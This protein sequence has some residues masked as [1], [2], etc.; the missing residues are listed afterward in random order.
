MSLVEKQ[1]GSM[2]AELPPKA[3]KQTVKEEFKD[4][5]ERDQAW[6]SEASFMTGEA[7]S[8]EKEE[9]DSESENED[10]QS[11]KPKAASGLNR[12]CHRGKESRSK[13]QSWYL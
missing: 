11:V 9:S 4:F 12:K 5:L 13:K 6:D 3:R 1:S 8:S 7:A 2:G 10:E